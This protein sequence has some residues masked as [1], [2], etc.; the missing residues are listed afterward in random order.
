MGN[1][2]SI[3]S[4]L[5]VKTSEKPGRV[6]FLLHRTWTVIVTKTRSNKTNSNDSNISGDNSNCSCSE[7]LGDDDFNDNR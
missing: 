3:R 7:C 1:H 5:S 2:L 6:F 4:N